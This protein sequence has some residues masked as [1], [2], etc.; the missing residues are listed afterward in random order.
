MKRKVAE[1]LQKLTKLFPTYL[2][3]ISQP[4]VFILMVDDKG[5]IKRVLHNPFYTYIFSTGLWKYPR[6]KRVLSE[7][8]MK[9]SYDNA[10]Q[11][12][13]EKEQE[14]E[15]LLKQLEEQEQKEETK[16]GGILFRLQHFIKNLGG[17]KNGLE[18]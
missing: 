6:P 2:E 11:K 10:V 7:S 15:E 17:L 5:K 8:K 14:K 1:I 18:K 9:E 3:L 16:K 13:K 12:F 4:H